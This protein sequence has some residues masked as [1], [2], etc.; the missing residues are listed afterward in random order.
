M[1]SYKEARKIV[2]QA[3]HD[4]YHWNENTN[5][6]VKMTELALLVNSAVDSSVLRKFNRGSSV[7]KKTNSSNDGTN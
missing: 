2:L 1:L 3:K 4:S 7:Y 5:L 6:F